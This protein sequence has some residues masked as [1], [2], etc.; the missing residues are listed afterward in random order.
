MEELM[1]SKEF[2]VGGLGWVEKRSRSLV[3]QQ[4]S[5][6]RCPHWFGFHHGYSEWKSGKGL[7]I[8]TYLA[9]LKQLWRIQRCLTSHP[10]CT[11][12][13]RQRTLQGLQGHIS[14]CRCLKRWK[15]QPSHVTNETNWCCH[16]RASVDISAEHLG[17]IIQAD[18]EEMHETL[19][20][21]E[22]FLWNQAVSSA[23]WAREANCMTNWCWWLLVYAGLV[24]DYDFTSRISLFSGFLNIILYIY[25]VKQRDLLSKPMDLSPDYVMSCW[26]AIPTTF[27]YIPKKGLLSN[28]LPSLSDLLINC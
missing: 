8:L 12:S 14:I 7:N 11:V 13:W 21:L 5:Q 24:V 1:P 10:K 25:H 6:Q 19:Q 16:D 27:H 9:R 26:L 3:S 23:A 2:W 28:L 20:W 18:V 15:R 22:E 4:G 17:R